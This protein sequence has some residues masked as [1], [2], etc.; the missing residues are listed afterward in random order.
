MDPDEV[1]AGGGPPVAEQPGL[2]VLDGDRFF[3]QG[4]AVQVDLS[5]GE[6]VG[7]APP[8]VDLPQD[9]GR[10]RTFRHEAPPSTAQGLSCH[11]GR[12]EQR[13][14]PHPLPCLDHR[15]SK[16]AGA[17]RRARSP[18]SL[19]PRA[20]SHSEGA[21]CPAKTSSR[22]IP[23]SSRPIPPAS[24]HPKGRKNAAISISRGTKGRE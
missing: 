13:S 1:E 18:A 14:V 17:K 20:S 12:W 6:I 21:S 7:R 11:N 16:S 23:C 9:F 10:E 3:K 19:I 4:I 8:R 5:H 15:L 22:L 24:S 2:D